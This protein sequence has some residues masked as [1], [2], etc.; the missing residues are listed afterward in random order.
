MRRGLLIS[1]IVM[2]L[3]G[4]SANAQRFS[5]STNLLDYACLGTMNV[6]GAY[7]VSRRWS[8]T[9]GAEYNPFT[10]RKGSSDQFQIRQQSYN[11]GARLWPWHTWSG[12]WFAGKIRYQEYNVGGLLSDITDEGDRA[13]AGLYVGYTYML[14]PHFNM[15]FGL[16]AWG[17]LDWFNRYSC[18]VCGLTMESGRRWFV[19]PD[20]IMIAL[21]YVF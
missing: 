11:V 15:E 5:L 19:L 1:A 10:F 14:G 4:F 12:W 17:G 13:G 6:E 16:G 3:T 8:L 20:D 9:L 21:V 7:S 2:A 18:Q